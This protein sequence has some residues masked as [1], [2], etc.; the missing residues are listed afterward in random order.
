[1][2]WSFFDSLFTAC[3]A[4]ATSA[5][6]WMAYKSI[7]E[8]RKQHVDEYRPIL[9]LSPKDSIDP[10]RR[11]NF[12][13]IEPQ[14]TTPGRHLLISGMLKNVGCGPALNARLTIRFQ[15]IEGYGVT[16]ELS[17]IQAGGIYGDAA[18][19]MRVLFPLSQKFNDSD[20]QMASG[21]S[22]EI[23]FE[24]ED[25]FGQSFFTL[26]AKNPQL[27]WTT[28][29]KGSAPKGVPQDLHTRGIEHIVQASK[30]VDNSSFHD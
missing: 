24:Y 12:L 28:I 13:E 8:S 2:N 7:I 22:W 5:M 6:A 14:N 3:S 9:V 21:S 17:P 19:P 23:I 20:F 10:V 11:E 29:G 27:P 1:M 26:H 30:H 25:L 4:V 16:R 18:Y 15:G